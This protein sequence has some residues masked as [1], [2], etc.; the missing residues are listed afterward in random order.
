MRRLPRL[1]MRIELLGQLANAVGEGGG[2][3]GV[4]EGEG[5]R[6]EAACFVVARSIFQ[7]AACCK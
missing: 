3:A 2:E 4:V 6:F 1:A 5:E 7:S